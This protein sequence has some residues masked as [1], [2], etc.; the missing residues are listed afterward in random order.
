[1][2]TYKNWM[3]CIRN[4]QSRYIYISTHVQKVSCWAMRF[5]AW[6]ASFGQERHH[7][8][9]KAF[10]SMAKA[11]TWEAIWLTGSVVYC[12]LSGRG[13]RSCGG[14]SVLVCEVSVSG[15]L[16]H[17]GQTKDS[18][19]CDTDKHTSPLTPLTWYPSQHFRD[20][21]ASSKSRMNRPTK[22]KWWKNVPILML[23]A[24]FSLWTK[25]NF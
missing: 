20:Q 7:C 13:W 3:W 11:R 25:D 2:N 10:V 17:S 15:A 6:V 8:Q 21:S 16:C 18:W 4:S 12:W 14:R 9:L 22:I 1:M 24:S 23:H 5:S 19:M